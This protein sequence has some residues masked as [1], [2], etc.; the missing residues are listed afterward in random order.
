MNLKTKQKGF[1]LVELLIVIVVIAILAAISIVAYNGIQNRAK[2]TSAAATAATVVKKAEAA[3]AIASTYPAAAADFSAQSDSSFAGSGIELIALAS[4]TSSAK[5]NQVTYERCN[6]V[7]SGAVPNIARIQSW[8]YTAG[9]KAAYEYLGN[10]NAG[11]CTGW[12]VVTGG[13]Y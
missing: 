5:P 4:L 2:T 3:N 10:T 13:P 11:S 6:A 12:V 7:A 8:D 9:A 1:T